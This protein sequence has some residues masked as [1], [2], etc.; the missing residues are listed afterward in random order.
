MKLY[1]KIISAVVFIACIFFVFALKTVPNGKIWK[2]YSVLY[3]PV[4]TS[5]SVVKQALNSSN[6]KDFVSL[7]GQYLPVNLNPNS[8]EI[9]LL[10]SQSEDVKYSYF[11]KIY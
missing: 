4:S 10:K 8:P 9:S 5:D 11:I 3:V 1:Q 6:V 7:S 2:E